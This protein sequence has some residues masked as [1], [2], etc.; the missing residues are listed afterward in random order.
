MRK[1]SLHQ[2]SHDVLAQ[3]D[4]EFAQKTVSEPAGPEMREATLAEYMRHIQR[5]EGKADALNLLNGL[6][7][8]ILEGSAAAPY[9]KDIVCDYAF[10]EAKKVYVFDIYPVEQ[11]MVIEDGDEISLTPADEIYVSSVKK[12][13]RDF[14]IDLQSSQE[15]RSVRIRPQDGEI[16]F[17][18]KIDFLKLLKLHLHDH[19]VPI[20]NIDK[21][22]LQPVIDDDPDI[23]K[24]HRKDQI[25]T[26]F[27]Q[28]AALAMYQIEDGSDE[29]YMD[30]LLRNAFNASYASHEHYLASAQI[31]YE[32]LPYQVIS[33][34]MAITVLEEQIRI[35]DKLG[36]DFELC[37]EE[38]SFFIEKRKCSLRPTL[39]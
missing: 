32:N 27:A 29:N 12:G 24:L 36:R 4:L 15:D 14:L 16:Q 17:E 3:K 7:I 37:Q 26:L 2:V 10:D 39:N 34:N 20:C 9:T 11:T 1:T 35:E 5:E 6:L 21:M 31:S 33:V 22:H 23:K 8:D 25:R 38:G 28:K 30:D 13:I 18:R 19:G